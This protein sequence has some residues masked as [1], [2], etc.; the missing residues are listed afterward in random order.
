MGSVIVATEKRR[1]AGGVVAGLL[2]MAAL[3]VTA[4]CSSQASPAGPGSGPG[5]TSTTSAN[6]V[7]WSTSTVSLTASDFWIVADGQ[8]YLANPNAVDVHSDP[9]D[10]MYTTLELVWTEHGREMRFFTYFYSDGTSSW[11]SNE[12]RT[13]NGQAS[14]DWLFYTGM[15]FQS[16][17]GSA[18]KGDVDLTNDASD[19]IRGELHLHGVVLMTP[20]SIRLG[21]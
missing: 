19:A 2:G 7:A 12:M 17:Y 9:G 21:P 15:F 13:Y 8:T 6:P 4:G 5:P 20:W 14:S 1:T 16:P 11:W 3:A 18:F 10:S